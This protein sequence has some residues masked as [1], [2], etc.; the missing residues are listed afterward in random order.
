M[1]AGQYSYCDIYTLSLFPLIFVAPSGA[2]L[3][4]RVDLNNHISKIHASDPFLHIHKYTHTH[5]YIYII[6]TAKNTHIH[7]HIHL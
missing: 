5:T 4:D 6:D 7:T 3:Y 2:L 1:N